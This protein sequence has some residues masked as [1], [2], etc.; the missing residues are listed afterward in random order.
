VDK[1]YFWVFTDPHA[2]GTAADIDFDDFRMGALQPLVVDE[3]QPV[4]NVMSAYDTVQTIGATYPNTSQGKDNLSDG[5]SNPVR[6][7]IT[8]GEYPGF[9]IVPYMSEYTIVNG[10]HI[11]SSNTSWEKD[12]AAYNLQGRNDPG[13]AWA[14][15][16]EGPIALDPARN[17]G[18]QQ[19]SDALAHKSIKFDN[20][21]AYKE[22][23]L[24]FP[25]VKGASS[26][27]VYFAN[28]ELSG[29][30]CPV[31]YEAPTRTPSPTAAPLSGN[32]ELINVAV[33]KPASQTSTA[34]GGVASR[35]V[36]GNADGNWGGGSVTHTGGGDQMWKV[37]LLDE[38]SV[39]E[40]VIWNRWDCGVCK[41]RL[42]RFAIEFL[43]END[44][45][46]HVIWHDDTI[47]TTRQDVHFDVSEFGLLARYVALHLWGGSSLHIAEFEVLTEMQVEAPSASPTLSWLSVCENMINE[48]ANAEDVQAGV[49]PFLKT[50]S[51]SELTIAEEGDA[52]A[53]VSINH[54]FS[55]EGRRGWYDG[56]FVEVPSRCL[57]SDATLYKISFRFRSHST[58]P[59]APRVRFN[60]LA[61]DGSWKY[62]LGDQN[63]R[64]TSYL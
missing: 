2:T 59:L 20:V 55:L 42:T 38:Y 11:Y 41:P 15:I 48:N 46:V 61:T 40:V 29:Y 3:L 39:K 7:A 35:A 37:D 27:E 14:L 52:N 51:N 54:Y 25:E 6:M 63:V 21:L 43:D 30:Y 8:P 23:R 34:H 5:T 33:D 57:Q 32:T 1:A 53:N 10:M 4:S 28:I 18:G 58:E 64:T 44:D 22:Y 12:P 47:D 13:E 45:P 60:Y 19:I 36:D 17:N 16:S 9:D 50:F 62:I 26:T 56:I 49:T 31:D 24:T